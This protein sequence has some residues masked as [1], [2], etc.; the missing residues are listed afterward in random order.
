MFSIKFKALCLLVLLAGAVEVSAQTRTLWFLYRPDPATPASN[1]F[2]PSVRPV[3]GP[4]VTCGANEYDVGLRTLPQVAVAAGPASRSTPMFRAATEWRQAVLQNNTTGG[5]ITAQMRIV[6]VS[7]LMRFA[8]SLL[9]LVPEANGDAFTANSILFDSYGGWGSPPSPCI[10][11][12]ALNNGNHFQQFLGMSLANVPCMKAVTKDIPGFSLS[13]TLIVE[14]RL[15]R[16]QTAQAG[17]YTGGVAYS[18]GPGLDVDFGDTVVPGDPELLINLRLEVDPIFKV[19]FPGGSTLMSLEPDGGW[20]NWL[21]RGRKPTRLWREQAFNFSTSIPFKMIM[22][23]EHTSGNHCAIAAND[24]HQVP[25]EIRMTLPPGMQDSAGRPVRDY[26][27]NPHE[28]PQLDPTR[29]ILGQKGKLQFEVPRPDMESML[30]HAG[31]AYAGQVTFI[32][33]AQI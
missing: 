11:R 1:A 29:I 3:C 23:C 27:L 22:Q 19:E 26:L 15:P 9:E 21:N 30:D 28:T 4:F 8:T 24:G 31:K 5:T 10:A 20:L 2:V 18:V 33:D 17:I 7:A 16:P 6:G 25:V 32:W 14:V 12:M 13:P